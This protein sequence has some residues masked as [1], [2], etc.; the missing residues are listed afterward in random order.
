MPSQNP[1]KKHLL[2]E[3][4]LRT[5]LR[6]VRLHD[7]LGVH[8]SDAE[9]LHEALFSE[10]KIWHPQTRASAHVRLGIDNLSGKAPLL[11]QG[12]R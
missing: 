9:L 5:L 11:G 8:P 7:P 6:S 12:I 10:S 1:S 2:V 4:L 3:N